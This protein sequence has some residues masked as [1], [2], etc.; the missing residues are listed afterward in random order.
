MVASLAVLVGDTQRE[1]E[2]EFPLAPVVHGVFRPVGWVGRKQY[3]KSPPAGDNRRNGWYR[4]ASA[5]DDALG[6]EAKICEVV[7]NLEGE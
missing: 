7:M 3:T 4:T 6:V 5:S 2:P 1:R